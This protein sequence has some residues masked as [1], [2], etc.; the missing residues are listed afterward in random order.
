MPQY[1]LKPNE[2]LD[3]Y[4]K[5]LAAERE[6]AQEAAAIDAFSSTY[7]ERGGDPA[8]LTKHTQEYLATRAQRL[9]E[10]A[11]QRQRTRHQGEF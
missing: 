9:A 2:T 11:E 3:D 7:L 4:R 8:G 6:A 5:R 1:Q 10:A